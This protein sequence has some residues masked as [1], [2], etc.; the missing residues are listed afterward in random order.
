LR[1]TWPKIK[2]SIEHLMKQDANQDGLLEGEQYNTL[3]ASW[4]GEIAWI[5]SLYLACVRA[6]AAMA[7]E[8]GD[9]EFAKRCDAINDRG[10]KR[11]V[12]RLFNGEYFIQ[13]VDPNHPQAINTND[14]C[15][16]DQ[17]FGQSYAWQ[18]GLERVVPE[19][20]CLS[21]LQSL[22]RYSFTPD[23]GPY[24]KN[25]QAIKTGRWYA[26]SG[27]GGLLMCTWPKGGAE[28]AA[29]TGN[30]TFVG[31][32]NECMTGFEYQV[33]AHMIWEGLVTEGLAITRTIHDRYHAAKRNPYNEVECSDHYS[34]AM[35][36]YG[37]FLAAC[38]FEHHGPN[39]H[40]GFA[41]KLTP[42]YFRAPFT[43][44]EGWGTFAQKQEAGS[45]HAVLEVKWGK[46]RL[47]SCA[48][49]VAL[50]ARPTQVMVALAGK[51]IDAALELKQRR[52]QVTFNS[53]VLIS[54]GQILELA[55]S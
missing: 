45:Q 29:G 54:A 44:A 30:P 43:A 12:E 41:P 51:P 18:L 13:V 52:A 42:A 40:I 22:W 10:S 2:K 14:G 23:I 39:G 8:M 50:N 35:M 16:I 32:F 7:R 21:A 53:E 9:E 17:V 55:L 15:H 11:L 19:K 1:R 24:R 6:G 38:G 49:E 3:D 5:S 34:R 37:V 27:E 46:L 31:Y 33:A 20:E 48:L 36:S 4:Y 47:R 26:M 25:F 28:K